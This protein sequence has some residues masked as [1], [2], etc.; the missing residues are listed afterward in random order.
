MAVWGY[1]FYEVRFGNVSAHW[2]ETAKVDV[3]LYMNDTTPRQHTGAGY[4]F[5]AFILA[6]GLCELGVMGRV[7]MFVSYVGELT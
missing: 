5:A 3:P 4:F 1:S 7:F 2:N 6:M